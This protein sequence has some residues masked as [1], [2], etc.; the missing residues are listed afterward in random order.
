[1]AEE[2]TLI[3]RPVYA[4]TPTARDV[5]AVF[6][7]QRRL[8]ALSFLSIFLVALAY[9]MLTPSYVAE[10]KVLV[11]R[12]RQDPLITPVP[13]SPPEFARDQ[14]SEEELNSE[15]ELLRDQDTLRDVVEKASLASRGNW[16]SAWMNKNSA[17]RVEHAVR[18]LDQH[19]QIDPL[20]KSTIIL[21][22]YRSS[23]PQKAAQ[24]LE[25]LG[26]AYLKRHEEVRRPIGEFEF[27]DQQV[28]VAQR[29]LAESESRLLDFDREQGIVSASVERD[30]VL[31]QLSEAQ[32][33]ELQTRVK[34]SETARRISTLEQKIHSLPERT[35]TAIR[36]SDNP[37]LLQKLKSTL[38][39]LQLKRT[40]LLTKFEPSYRLVQEV[41]KQ[42]AE[43]KQ[44]I[45]AQD[46]L[47]L[48][49]ETTQPEPN[50]EWA[51]AELIK[52]Q[53]DFASLAERA[54]ATA[55]M[56]TSYQQSAQRLE[57]Q[58]VQQEQL[59]K[60]FE[61]SESK[62]LLYVN[63]REEARIADALDKRAI[64]N[65]AIAEPPAV[66]ALPARSELSFA[67][68]GIAAAAVGSTGLSFAA[69]YLSPA[70]RTPDEVKAYLNMPVLAS[71]PQP[72][73]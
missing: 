27:F 14:V 12:G 49:D 1:M 53:V 7:R 28:H 36:N 11:R 23:S 68:L 56:L 62:Y 26:A 44:A 66:P 47:P 38:L 13:T 2:L 54:K 52:A 3:S 39:D 10:M 33:V 29:E 69:D 42:I 55:T 57:Q 73:T 64:L 8:F 18:H 61:A 5:A 51:K 15:A 41:D 60:D 31:Q 72:R 50:R 46:Q 16:L 34:L 58:S 24:V 40:A 45:A 59:L 20:K 19:L 48:R 43:A 32:A 65:V 6:F 35:T 30:Q 71:L 25:L 9:G 63:K 70:F 67:L 21:V 17:A 4:S 22:R 37:E